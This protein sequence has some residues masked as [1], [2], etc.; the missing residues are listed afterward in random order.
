MSVFKMRYALN[1]QYNSPKCFNRIVV[2]VTCTLH[3][4]TKVK[5][6]STTDYISHNPLLEF[7]YWP[8]SVYEMRA[9][10]PNLFLTDN[11]ART[12]RRMCFCV[13]AHAG[14]GYYPKDLSTYWHAQATEPCRPS[15]FGLPSSFTSATHPHLCSTL[16]PT[17]ATYVPTGKARD[18]TSLQLS[19]HNV[20]GKIRS[21]WISA[22]ICL[23]VFMHAC[24]KF[25]ASSK[26]PQYDVTWKKQALNEKN[27]GRPTNTHTDTSIHTP[28]FTR[29]DLFYRLA[30]I[31]DTDNI[32]IVT[33]VGVLFG[34]VVSRMLK[35]SIT[36]TSL[37]QEQT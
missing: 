27:R 36:L 21:T 20:A 11:H 3:I 29:W 9:S 16:C 33:A 6:R 13:C 23:H 2:K 4:K 37:S 25:P 22:C 8:Y 28:S 1:H 32:A 18:A 7:G 10:L 5:L 12:W 17:M 35:F 24:S 30:T 19:T 15:I 14:W 34:V 31:K 26:L